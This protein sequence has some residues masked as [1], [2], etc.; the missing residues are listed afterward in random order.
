MFYDNTKQLLSAKSHQ[1]LWQTMKHSRT[2]KNTIKAYLPKGTIIAHK[3]GHSGKNKQ[4]LT[5]AEND[6]GIVFLN[7]GRRFYLS[8]FVS[9]SLESRDVNQKIIADIAKLAWDYFSDKT[10]D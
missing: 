6:I 9:D 1:L 2:G 5:G 3:T 7:N 4:G 10:S 8:V